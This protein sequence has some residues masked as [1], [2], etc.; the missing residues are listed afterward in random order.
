MEI[1]EQRPS[2]R[3]SEVADTAV[4]VPQILRQH[5]SRVRKASPMLDMEAHIEAA[6]AGK[7]RHST[8]AYLRA[9][10]PPPLQE[11]RRTG[12]S[13]KA[14]DSCISRAQARTTARIVGRSGANTKRHDGGGG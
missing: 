3:G 14:L 12:C 6:G 7:K 2:P 4:K 9:Q 10:G 8:V 5:N 1:S 13:M 11:V